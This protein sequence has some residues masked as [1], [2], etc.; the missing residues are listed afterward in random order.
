MPPLDP[1]ILVDHIKAQGRRERKSAGS[2]GGSSLWTLDPHERLLKMPLQK[3]QVKA[4]KRGKI[5]F[6]VSRIRHFEYVRA[7]NLGLV[8]DG[9]VQFRQN[10]RVHVTPTPMLCWRVDLSLQV[11][12]WARVRLPRGHLELATARFQREN[13]T[14]R[15][16]W[17]AIPHRAFFCNTLYPCGRQVSE[18]ANPRLAQPRHAAVQRR[19]RRIEFGRR[20]EAE[21]GL[22][23]RL[24]KNAGVICRQAK[25]A[26]GKQREKERRENYTWV[27]TSDET[28][29]STVSVEKR[30]AFR[31][32]CTVFCHLAL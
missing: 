1:S 24:A 28:T 10:D 12:C 18:T 21:A 2:H 8:G 30:L 11:Y 32:L 16:T 3:E 4:Q 27:G 13:T 7:Q 5:V 31:N 9:V 19:S 6:Y 25:I 29:P 26:E 20:R 15:R 23:S 17:C 14:F 22:M